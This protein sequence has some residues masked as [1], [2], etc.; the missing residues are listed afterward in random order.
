M[1]GHPNAARAGTVLTYDVL[2][3]AD[4]RWQ[5]GAGRSLHGPA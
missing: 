3:V 5:F 4:A 1:F 2:F